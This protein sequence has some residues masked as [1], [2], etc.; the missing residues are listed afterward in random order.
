MRMIFTGV[1]QRQ[2]AGL[3][4]PR[5]LDRNESPVDEAVPL[6]LFSSIRKRKAAI[7]FKRAVLLSSLCTVV[8]AHNSALIKVC[9][10]SSSSGLIAFR[11]PSQSRCVPSSSILAK[12]FVA[13]DIGVP[14]PPS[15]PRVTRH[16]Y[17]KFFVT[18][19]QH[20]SLVCNSERASESAAAGTLTDHFTD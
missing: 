20:G 15:L 1:A 2:R 4:T 14:W 17:S 8:I 5:S 11:C 3:I 13:R 16:F 19:V 9:L 7:R 12:K 6:A 18:R 10:H